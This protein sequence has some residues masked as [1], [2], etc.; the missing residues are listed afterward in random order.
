MNTTHI[1]V[2]FQCRISYG[3]FTLPCAIACIHICAHVKD[4]VVHVRV[5][6]LMETHTHT[7]KTTTTT[8]T[9]TTNKHK[10]MRGILGIATLSQ[11]AFPRESN[12]NFQW[13]KSVWN[14]T[15]KKKKKEEEALCA[16]TKLVRIILD[17]GW[18]W[19]YKLQ[20]QHKRQD[21]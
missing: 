3:V 5:R 17:T 14:N 13:E 16:S 18:G 4:P 6:W 12:L 9:T 8:T 1:R 10:N 11:L 20:H 7:H 21:A 19:G 2:N 15:G